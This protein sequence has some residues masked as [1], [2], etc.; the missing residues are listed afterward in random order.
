MRNNCSGVALTGL[1]VLALAGCGGGGGGSP[2]AGEGS[3]TGGGV[4]APASVTVSG[5]AATG[6]AFTGA[7]VS[8]IDSRGVTVG[9]SQPVGSDGTYS[10]ALDAAAVAPF[11]LVARRT[12]ANGATE[13]LVSVIASAAVTTANI[14]PITTLIA[15][16]LSPSGDPAKLADELAAGQAPISAQ[17]VADTV[18]EVQAILANLLNATNTATVDPLTGSF[19]TDGTGYDRLLDSLNISFQPTSAS[20]TNIEIT[21]RQEVPEGQQP[22]NLSFSSASSSV[23]PLPAIDP[24]TLVA[25]GTSVKIADFLKALTACYA[26]PASQRATAPSTVLAPQCL[27]VFHDNN[28]ALY[29]SNGGTVSSTGSFAGLFNANV[30]NTVFSQGSYEFTRGNAEKDIVVA[31]KTTLAD[32]S[33]SYDTLVLRTSASDGKLRLIGNQHRFPGRVAAYQQRRNFISLGQQAYDYFSTGYTLDVANRQRPSNLGPLFNRVIVTT[34]TGSS[35]TLKPSGNASFLG[36]VKPDTT[37]TGTSFVRLRSEYVDG[38]ASRPHPRDADP[39][40]FFVGTDRSEAD[41]AAAKSLG[42][43]KFEY[44]LNVDDPATPQDDTVVPEVQYYKNRARALTI[45]ELRTQGLAPM[46][47]GLIAEIESG[48]EPAGGPDAGKIVFAANDPGDLSTEGDGPGWSVS[49][50]QLPP[51]QITMFGRSPASGSNANFT[52]SIEVRSTVRKATVPCSPQ[53]PTDDHC[54]NGGPG[55]AAGSRLT[56]VH[57]FARDV[58]GRE[59]ANFYALY[60]LNIAP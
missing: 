23:A 53:S 2:S 18:T 48:T 39:T 8:V 16:R 19:S 46:T 5:V 50:G 27:D 26:L 25:E 37:V 43:W 45:A 36:L 56:G 33:E 41:L 11:V 35:L 17:A 47:P 12:D 1:V 49:A 14:T 21:V 13:T 4:V 54:H 7:V 60:P 20:S 59:F 38:N 42:S 28:P 22:T 10:I 58:V 24:T 6:A 40:L 29:K 15:S 44:Y 57:L 52:D 3:S 31:Y 9:Q 51:T 30:I 32:G 55:F 34:P